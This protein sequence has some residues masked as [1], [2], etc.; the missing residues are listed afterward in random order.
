M[1]NAKTA[2]SGSGEIDIFSRGEFASKLKDATS[3]TAV[4]EPVAAPTQQTNTVELDAS[5]PRKAHVKPQR[6]AKKP[7]QKPR[8]VVEPDNN[9]ENV[10]LRFRVPS[11]LKGD[12]SE[13]KGELS[14]AL[15][16]SLNDSNL[17]RPLFELLMVDYREQ[18]LE[19]A[20][21]IR[22]T[23]KRPALNDRMGM[24]EFDEEIG[25]MLKK[26]IKQRRKKSLATE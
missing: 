4:G 12:W 23:L 19:Q 2:A 24:A 10:T 3:K 22:G 20:A 9:T 18:I 15:G 25:Q 1:P 16:V 11:G 8:V 5:K 26:A 17:G 14:S 13:F 6:P 21:E 7:Q